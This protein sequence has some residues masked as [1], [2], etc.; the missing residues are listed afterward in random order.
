MKKAFFLVLSLLAWQFFLVPSPQAGEPLRVG[1]YQN[2]PKIFRD[3]DGRP[4]GFFIDILEYIAAQEG[5]RLKYVPGLWEEGLERL[6]KGQIDLMPDVA[7]SRERAKR[8]DF[9]SVNVWSNWALIYAGRGSKIESLT[10][11]EGKKIAAMRFDISYDDF[12]SI[13]KSFGIQSAFVEVP[14]FASVL[15]LIQEGA[16]DAGIVS[17]LYGLQYEQEYDVHRTSIVCCPRNLRF[18]TSKGAN[19]GLIA[20]IDEHLLTLKSDKQSLYYK[21]LARWIESI[22]PWRP[23]PWL[24][25]VLISAAAAAALLLGGVFIL[26]TQVKARTAELSDKNIRLKAQITARERAEDELRRV[27]RALKALSACNQAVIR[28]ADEA[29]LMEEMCRVA[30]EKAGYRLAWVGLAW[31][32]DQKTVQPAAQWG[33]EDSYLENINITWAD[34]ELGRGPTG[35]AIRTRQPSVCQNVLTDPAFAPWRADAAARGYG[36]SIAL[37][38]AAGEGPTAALNIYAAEPD[39]FDAEEVNLLKE[40][41]DDLAYGL[42]TLRD[43]VEKKRAEEEIRRLSQFLASVIDNAEVWLNVLDREGNV[44]LWNTAAEKISGYSRA[45]VVGHGQIWPW[46][47]PDEAYR[48]EIMAQAMAII[49]RG[50][51]LFNFTTTIVSKDGQKKVIAWNSRHL[52]D[53]KGSPSG[54]IAIGR[55]VSAEHRLEAQLRQLQ[56][57]ESIGTLAGGIAH[58][59]NNIL[60]AII[61]YTELAQGEID[62]GHPAGRKLKEVFKAGRRARDLVRQILTFSRISEESKAPVIIGPIIKEGLKLLRASLPTTIDIKA[63]V[64]VGSEAVMADPTQIHQVLMNLCTNAAQAMRQRGGALEVSLKPVELDEDAAARYVELRPGRYERLIVSDSG[65]GMDQAT[66]SR[67]FDPFFT[68]K[69]RGEGTGLGLSVVHGIVKSHGGAIGAYSEKGKGSTFQVYLPLLADRVEDEEVIEAAPVVGGRERILFVDDEA[70]LAELGQ[71]MLERL[72]YEVT[73]LTSS[74]EALRLF[75]TDSEAFDL[76]ITDYTMPHLTGAELA[77]EI[78]KIRPRTP[79]I[80]CTGFSERITAQKAEALGL[81][82]FL[83]KPLVTRQ[84][85]EAVREVLD[86]ET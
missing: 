37:P 3:D 61:G 45:E 76:V 53:E 59:F 48:R 6:E 64:A 80:M 42:T 17:R 11:L 83:M 25:W 84:L 38:L 16:V 8:F 67:I 52:V 55:D 72:G 73:A 5:W 68:T 86:E 21:S 1:V 34:N 9:N 82:R 7:Y 41:A 74:L 69:K 85:A 57:M 54:S 4:K 33:F 28:A 56:K 31:Q 75:R 50:E 79:I 77:G 2:K 44:V 13:L 24:S 47:Y 23:P 70:V 10:D 20:A 46:L 22:A 63:D 15:N 26:K 81:K 39:A 40:L 71:K 14:D 29:A 49:E 60:T 30:V 35:T 78:L 32:D 43:R 51:I 18:A 36:S 62:P 66:L 58:D 19:Q 12:K 65:E 27:N